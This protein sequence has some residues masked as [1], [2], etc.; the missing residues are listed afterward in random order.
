MSEHAK[1]RNESEAERLDRNLME[2][3]QELRVAIPGIQ[4]LFAFLLVVPFQQGWAGVTDFQRTVYYATLLLTVSSS[5]CLLAPTARHRLRFRELDKEWVVN[6]AN[7]LLVAGLVFLAG[8][9]CGAVTLITLVVYDDALAITVL[10]AMVVLI[11]W[12]W[13]AAPTVRALRERD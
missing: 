9:I 6:S 10:A 7:R 13:F 1:R 2:L 4:F 3:I 8:A 11:G 5:I 12:F